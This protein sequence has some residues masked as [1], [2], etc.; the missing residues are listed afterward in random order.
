L[1]FQ[2]LKVQPVH[3]E[4]REK[5]E[6]TVHLALLESEVPL[7]PPVTKVHKVLSVTKD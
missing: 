5:K 3:L 2:D 6:F 1:E 7:D 4:F